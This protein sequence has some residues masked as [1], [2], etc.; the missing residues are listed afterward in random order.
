MALFQRITLITSMRPLS[1]V[2]RSLCSNQKDEIPSLTFAKAF[3]KFEEL[4]HT[5]T[6][7]A[8]AAASAQ[9]AA[10]SQPVK[11]DFS[12]LT[13]LRNSPLMQMGDP[14]GRIVTGQIFH[15]VNDDLYIDFG[16]KFHCVCSRPSNNAE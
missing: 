10:A 14:S 3:Q 4:K 12:F 2:I 11:E 13:L 8:E 5:G 7:D 6:K 1:N 16:G 15:V 9:T